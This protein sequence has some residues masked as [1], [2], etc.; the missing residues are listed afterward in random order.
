[1]IP[2][3][4]VIVPFYNVEE[5]ITTCLES[6]CAQ[7]FGE[8]EVICVD[9]GSTDDSLIVAQKAVEGDERFIFIAQKNYGQSAARNRGIER[10]RGT[11]LLCLDSD[12]YYVPET[13]ACLYE[14]A[15]A[16]DLDDLFFSALTF[17]GN[18][19]LKHTNPE[20]F[21]DRVSIEGVM[22]GPELFVQFEKTGAFRPSAALH[23][24]RRSLLCENAIR[25]YEG[26]IHE[27]L[28]FTVQVITA[29]KRAAF[30]NEAYYMRRMREGSTMTI[31]R[32]LRNIDG[33]YRVS[34]ELRQL[35][36]EKG[37]RGGTAYI[38]ALAH[39]IFYCWDV[40]A[41]DIVTMRCDEDKTCTR[42][43]DN[44]KPDYLLQ[45]E[46]YANALPIEER[47]DFRLHV[48]E[49]AAE[50]DRIYS[51]LCGSRTYRVGRV[52]MALP[53]WLKVRFGALR[54]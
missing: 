16:D 47:G 17:Y 21:D 8:F 29:A 41:H 24:V 20:D 50:V 33:L 23:M 32:S 27:D 5:Y 38:D 39:R 36:N 3:I 15:E 10:A 6:L 43:C 42:R 35:L 12:D 19:K 11:Y 22:S 13:L 54:R 48:I 31:K 25:F 2:R 45:L 9:D 18:F 34:V 30:M 28:L 53:S 46:A 49:H 26:I 40:I 4:S 37:P 52:I 44:E 51:D 1:M 7:T 14:R